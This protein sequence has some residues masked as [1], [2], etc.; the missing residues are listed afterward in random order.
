LGA[1]GFAVKFYKI[2][3]LLWK[4]FFAMETN[5]ICAGFELPFALFKYHEP[6]SSS[7]YISGDGTGRRRRRRRRRRR[8]RRRRRRR[9]RRGTRLFIFRS[10]S[11]STS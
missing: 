10:R 5:P 3:R 1:K 6:G 8:W 7:F 2:A 4:L 9:W 11:K